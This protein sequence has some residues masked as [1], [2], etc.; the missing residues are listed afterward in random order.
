MTVLHSGAT[1]KYSDNWDNIFAGKKSAAK[2]S[3]SSKKKVAKKK[4]KA[5]AK[6]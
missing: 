3:G 4:K 2:A 5:K 1:K 6:K